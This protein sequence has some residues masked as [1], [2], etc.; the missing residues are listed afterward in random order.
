MDKKKLIA[1]NFAR[2]IKDKNLLQRNVADA[3]GKT[4]SEIS[5]WLSGKNGI[6]HANII[7]INEV[8]CVDLEKYHLLSTQWPLSC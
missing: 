8:F 4:E 3:L 1:E 6:S 5:R 2:L 7:K